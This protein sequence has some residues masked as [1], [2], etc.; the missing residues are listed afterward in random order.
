MVAEEFTVCVLHNLD[1]YKLASRCLHNTVRGAEYKHS[2]CPEELESL[3][4][5][6]QFL[7]ANFDNLQMC[8]DALLWT[9]QRVEMDYLLPPL[10]STPSYRPT[11]QGRSN[12]NGGIV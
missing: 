10:L 7:H 1:A 8:R 5:L 11:Y 12:A 6:C 9:F 3:Q 4:V 2:D